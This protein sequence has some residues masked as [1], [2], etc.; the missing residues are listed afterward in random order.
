VFGTESGGTREGGSDAGAGR[1]DLT[2]LA[3]G[4]AG[5]VVG[6]RGGREAVGRLEAMGIGVG[7]VIEKESSALRRGPIVIRSGRTLVA[8]GFGIAKG[9]LVEPID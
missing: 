3:D 2:A 5:R 8:L 9:I 4:R 6:L 1:M 7:S